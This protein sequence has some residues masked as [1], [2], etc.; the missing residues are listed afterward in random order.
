MDQK[1]MPEQDAYPDLDNPLCCVK[2]VWVLCRMKDVGKSKADIAAERI[3]ARIDGVKVTPHFCRIEEK[4]LEFFQ[5]FHIWVLGLDSLDARRYMNQIACSFLGRPASW[6]GPTNVPDL[7]CSDCL[8][9]HQ[10]KILQHTTRV[11]AS[12]TADFVA[13]AIPSQAAL[14]MVTRAS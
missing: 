4:P 9:T 6:T 7:L 10:W 13:T 11:L 12:E 1:L 8:P 14:V 5:D 3:M 2:K